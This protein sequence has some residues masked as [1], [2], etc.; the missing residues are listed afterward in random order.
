VFASRG[1]AQPWTAG[2]WASAA[3]SGEARGRHE[4]GNERGTLEPP[5]RTDRD[6]R[7]QDIPTPSAGAQG[8]E[9]GGGRRA[10]ILG[11]Q[12]REARGAQNR[13][14][15]SRRGEERDREARA[16]E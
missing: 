7:R 15:A 8:G 9:V 13:L 12:H 6:P 2:A 11:E 10:V 14:G 5:Q 3:G 1:R 4:V 16:H